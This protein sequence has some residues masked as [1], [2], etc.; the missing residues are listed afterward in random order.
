MALLELFLQRN[1]VVCGF[2]GCACNLHDSDVDEFYAGL[3]GCAQA[4][5]DHGRFL[6]V[7]HLL[8]CGLVK[9]KRI[10]L[11]IYIN[12]FERR[13][14]KICAYQLRNAYLKQIENIS[15]LHL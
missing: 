2:V 13:L 3:G 4:C 14:K 10:K 7:H 15:Q 6:L 12:G 8:T 9:I 1:V 11:E 5:Q